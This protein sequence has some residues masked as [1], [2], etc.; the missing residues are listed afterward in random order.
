MPFYSHCTTNDTV[1]SRTRIISKGG[2]FLQYQSSHFDLS[3]AGYSND[4]KIQFVY[5]DIS[6][7]CPEF[8]VGIELL[9]IKAYQ[10]AQHYFQLAYESVKP[11]DVY[12]NKYASYCGFTRIL[13]GDHGGVELCR[14]AARSEMHDADIFLNLACAEWK[15]H[16]RRNTIKA[17]EK[18]IDIDDCHPGVRKM[19]EQL[20]IRRRQPIPILSRDNPINQSLGKF[21]RKKK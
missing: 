18:G 11:N 17:L 7:Y 10:K 1:A 15:F 12:H 2:S 6:Q 19:R 8:K 9:D 4:D 13:N 21:L 16:N 5:G 20:G 14:D 3:N